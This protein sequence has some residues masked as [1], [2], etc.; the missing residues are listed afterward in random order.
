[1]EPGKESVERIAAGEIVLISIP[2]S[3]FVSGA[4]VPRSPLISS[5]YLADP[6][7]DDMRF[8]LESRAVTFNFSDLRLLTASP[9]STS[10]PSA[11]NGLIRDAVSIFENR[12]SRPVAALPLLTHAGAPA[13][14]AA[15]VMEAF[16][17][18]FADSFFFGK[19]RARKTRA[20]KP[21][22]TGT[23]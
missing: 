9:S 1:M 17:L 20:E 6:G 11:E 12:F 22:S 14:T 13:R 18:S 21:S 10:S 3:I 4:R 7:W 8:R 2:D 15:R 19:Y 23:T 5:F 16:S